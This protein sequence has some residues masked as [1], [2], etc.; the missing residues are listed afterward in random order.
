VFGIWFDADESLPR[1]QNFALPVRRA[2][3]K[4]SAQLPSQLYVCVLVCEDDFSLGSGP[5]RLDSYSRTMP[6]GRIG[7]I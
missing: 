3:S 1:A 7:S 5:G 2:P 6:K 4:Q